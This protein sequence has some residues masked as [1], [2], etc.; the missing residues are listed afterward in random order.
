MKVIRIAIGAFL[1]FS[2]LFGGYVGYEGEGNRELEIPSCTSSELQQL[3]SDGS[4]FCDKSAMMDATIPIPKT[5][6]LIL[7]I[8]GNAY[9]DQPEVW[10]GIVQDKEA[11]K[12][13][14]ATSGTLICET[15]E[16]EFVAG[17]PNANGTFEWIVVEGD[18]RFIAGSTIADNGVT[19]DVE[20]TYAVFL[21]QPV[22][23]SIAA[24]GA[25][26]ILSGLK[27]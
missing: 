16:I 12:C 17:G 1:I 7:D 8:E 10:F 11:E 5:L 22:I 21:T 25:V 19:T 6:R 4:T 9:W 14:A 2:M 23:I 20:Y 26:L 18:Y 15:N 3:T 24:I 13:T 27:D